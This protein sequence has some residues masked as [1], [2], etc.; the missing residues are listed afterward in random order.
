MVIVVIRMPVEWLSPWA[1]RKVA[2][3]VSKICNSKYLN[4][5]KTS[6]K[7]KGSQTRA[8]EKYKTK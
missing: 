2:V 4:L 6:Y 7:T 5:F 3:G 1:W 8:F